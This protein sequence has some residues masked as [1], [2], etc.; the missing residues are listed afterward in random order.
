MNT[1]DLKAFNPTLYSIHNFIVDAKKLGYGEI[2]FT[3]KTHN[4]AAKVIDMKA[5][6]PKSKTL[7][8]S[9][10]KRIVVKKKEK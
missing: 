9:V 10:T 6:D 7:A 2:E 4:Y 8:K 1:K 5:V 3:I